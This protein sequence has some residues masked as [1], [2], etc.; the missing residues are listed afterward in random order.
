MPPFLTRLQFRIE[1]L[2]LRLL[3]GVMHLLPLD[4]AIR[5][6]GWLWHAIAP[7]LKRHAR[8]HA[9]L[10][11][12]MPELPA[13]ERERILRQM[14]R[15]LGMTFAESIMLDRLAREPDRLVLDPASAELVRGTAGMPTVMASFH[16]GNWEVASWGMLR[17]GL[18]FAGV[19]QKVRNPLVDA[20]IHRFRRD[21]YPLGLVP[22][23][24]QAAR[25]LIRAMSEGN[26]VVMMADLRELQG[27]TVPFFGRP[28]PST[29]FPATLARSHDG[30]LFAGR[31]V[32]TGPGRFVV[33][34][35]EIAVP[36]TE[37]R[38]ADII[39][40]TAALNR[41]FEE[42]IRLRP[43]QWMWAHR[44]FER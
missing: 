10:E 23:G 12:A 25:F 1:W 32:R 44:R 27:V 34:A 42:W 7:H 36:R 40:G 18:T 37:D 19:Y 6:N 39:A 33:D 26:A 21:F 5:F 14:W 2:V 35:V 17:C 28:A 13:Q 20:D 4:S 29:P 11:Q 8:A 38:R 31:V 43:E 3:Y 16:S 15:H 24:K 41:Q 30:R 9:H 22:K